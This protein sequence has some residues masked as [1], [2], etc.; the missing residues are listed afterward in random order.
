MRVLVVEDEEVVRRLMVRVLA[1]SGI[2]V[3]A[4]ARADLA[5]PLLASESFDLVLA[6]VTLP[7]LDGVRFASAARAAGFS[8]RLIIASGRELDDGQVLDVAAAGG[9]FLR[10]PFSPQQLLDAVRG[11]LA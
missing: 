1:S 11:G 10:K 2:E 3:R 4:E 7:G 6:D 9:G 8:G 5:L